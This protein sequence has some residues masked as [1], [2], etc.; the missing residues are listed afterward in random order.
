M[1]DT[2]RR[3][4]HYIDTTQS[5]PIPEVLAEDLAPKIIA[6]DMIEF[7][8]SDGLSGI[9]YEF[10]AWEWLI[11]FDAAMHKHGAPAW[12]NAATKPLWCGS[13][14]LEHGYWTESFE[15]VRAIVNGELQACVRDGEYLRFQDNG[16][17][18]LARSNV[19]PD[20]W[21]PGMVWA[22][23]SEC[24]SFRDNR[25][26]HQ[27]ADIILAAEEADAAACFLLVEQDQAR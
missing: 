15:T 21:E 10:N 26:G 14:Y 13:V 8:Q 11:R 18:V 5:L 6:G 2:P 19:D 9:T 12:A 17:L 23:G 25:H 1:T 27:L 7:V 4:T 3:T 20:R 24:I 22:D 16:F